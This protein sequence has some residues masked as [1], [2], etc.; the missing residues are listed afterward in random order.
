MRKISY[1]LFCC[2]L[3]FT[4][5]AQECFSA[6]Q[7]DFVSLRNEPPPPIGSTITFGYIPGFGFSDNLKSPSFRGYIYQLLRRMENFSDYEFAFKPFPDA[8][9]LLDSLRSGAV[10]VAVPMMEN[11][12][13]AD[14]FLFSQSPFGTSQVLIVKRGT[15]YAYHHDPKK[16]HGKTVASYHDSPLERIFDMYCQSNGIEVNYIRGNHLDYHTLD[17]D[18]YLVSS[19]SDNFQNH[20]SVL[21]L[22]RY[23]YHLLYRKGYEALDT[24]LQATYQ[25]AIIADNMLLPELF[26]QYY[27]ATITR[28]DL[29]A[30]EMQALADKT[31]TVGYSRYHPPLQYTNEEGEADGI[32]VEI[33]NLLAKRYNFKVRYI[34]YSLSD[35][36]VYHESF[37]LLLSLLGN[38][39]HE[40]RHYRRT[41]Q[42][43]SQPLMLI[44]S[45]DNARIKNFQN[46]SRNIGMLHYISVDTDS[47]LQ[48]YPRAT[49]NIFE[50]FGELVDAYDNGTV[51]S[52]LVTSTALTYL[53]S[54]FGDTLFTFGNSLNLPFRLFVSRKLDPI[55]VQVF[56]VIFDYVD[57][58]EFDEVL[59]RHTLDFVPSYSFIDFVIIHRYEIAIV[60]LL[61]LVAYV[62]T[63]YNLQSK[64]KLAVLDA[65]RIDSLSGFMTY[66]FFE[67]EVAK[68]MKKADCCEYD[69]ISVDIDSFKGITNHYSY[70]TAT[71]ILQSLSKTLEMHLRGR[72]GILTRPFADNVLIV[73]KRLAAETVLN[74]INEKVVPQVLRSLGE[75][76]PLTLSV[77]IYSIDNCQEQIYI[78]VDRANMARS[79]GKKEHKTTVYSFDDVLMEHYSTRLKITYAMDNALKNDEFTIVFQPKVDFTTLKLTGAEA[80]VRWRSSTGEVFY[81]S[82]F[83]PVFEENGFIH[84]LDVY[85]FTKVCEFIQEH[86]E[87]VGD[88]LISVNI[89]SRTMLESSIVGRLKMIAD[90]Y[91]VEPSRIELEITE[92][93]MCEDFAANKIQDFQAMGFAIS[94]DDFGAGVSSLNRLG[95]MNANILKLDKAFLDVS[96]E[97]F[98]GKVVVQDTI[99]MAKHLDMHV[100]AEGVETALQACWLRSLECDIA[101][102]YY[103]SKPLAMEDFLKQ[104]IE[105]T[106]YELPD[107]SVL[108]VTENE[109]K[110]SVYEFQHSKVVP[111]ST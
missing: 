70:D 104:L 82:S 96:D 94:I 43:Y 11:R 3:C 59:A 61:L 44:T 12:E 77:G 1:M 35:P 99:L 63:V 92:S 87:H 38:Y 32:A 98:R 68:L 26:L 7:S 86:E 89:S 10:D 15:D 23:N 88:K 4:C 18:F 76:Y 111:I 60:V 90:Y 55:Y 27:N 52:M 97:N 42:Y 85:V 74:L 84:K 95:S 6:G 28:R 46:K 22:T 25:K 8:P 56:N 78:M 53:N 16:L 50:T 72:H 39:E 57:P 37:D 107:I 41:E 29:T 51:D 58:G 47:V 79:R 45:K 24:I 14:E 21:P 100:V 106:V 75:N 5:F 101:Q 9:S 2:V 103:F 81:P 40:R 69:I 67:A 33:F 31:F 80:L 83:I 20:D 34:P 108:N 19:L 54:I 65:L 73:R 49:V 109:T 64:K 102:G 105:D 91:Q 13:R 48:E 17:A 71:E 30:E 66:S 62:F 36:E 110:G 93:A